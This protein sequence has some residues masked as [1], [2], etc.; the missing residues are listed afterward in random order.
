[1]IPGA[2]TWCVLVAR[3]GNDGRGVG[4]WRGQ[5]TKGEDGLRVR[6]M[7]AARDEEAAAKEQVQVVVQQ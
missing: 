2:R 5:A 7:K 6:K 1:M 4:W 3:S